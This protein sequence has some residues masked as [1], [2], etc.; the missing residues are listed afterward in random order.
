MNNIVDK[1]LDEYFKLFPTDSLFPEWFDAKDK[2]KI[3]MLKEAIKE[4]KNLS[5]TT[6]FKE[7]YEEK[8]IL[9]W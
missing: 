2:D 3:K 4:E 7:K 1:L 6:I 5:E 8:V 9:D